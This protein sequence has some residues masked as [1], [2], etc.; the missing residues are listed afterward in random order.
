MSNIGDKMRYNIRDH[1]TD[2]EVNELLD[3][4]G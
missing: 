2:R 3:V 1:L 4:F